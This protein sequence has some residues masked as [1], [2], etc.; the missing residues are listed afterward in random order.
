Q[1]HQYTLH[2]HGALPS[3]TGLSAAFYLSKHSD[4]EIDLFEK[5]DR[6]GGK[7]RTHQKDGYTIELGPESYL[8]RKTIMTELA[9]EICMG[10]DLVR[11]STGQSYIYSNN[12]LSALPK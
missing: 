5:D 9:E 6:A 11:N 10:E 4:L 8:A 3:F 7:I 1:G 2:L 12:K